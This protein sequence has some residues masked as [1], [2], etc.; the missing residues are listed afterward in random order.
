MGFLS[1]LSLRAECGQPQL[2]PPCSGLHIAITIQMTCPRISFPSA[3]SVR[4]ITLFFAPHLSPCSGFFAPDS[5]E[6]AFSPDTKKHNSNTVLTLLRF[7][8]VLYISHAGHGLATSIMRAASPSL[9]PAH[10]KCTHWLHSIYCIAVSSALCWDIGQMYPWSTFCSMPLWW[11]AVFHALVLLLTFPV[12]LWYSRLPLSSQFFIPSVCFFSCLTFFCRRRRGRRRVWCRRRVWRWG[13]FPTRCYSNH[14]AVYQRLAKKQIL[15]KDTFNIV[16]KD[17]RKLSW[18]PRAHMKLFGLK[19]ALVPSGQQ[20][21]K[22]R[23]RRLTN[24][25]GLGDEY[26]QTGDR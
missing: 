4:W 26:V 2:A 8:H 5:A 21:W 22:A 18:K 14:S 19:R 1:H 6:G 16:K 23:E 13:Q 11:F 12:A 17:A 9:L 24:I 25:A 3:F 15:H 10:W 20:V 7:L